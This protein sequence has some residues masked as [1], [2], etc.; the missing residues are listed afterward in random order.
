MGVLTSPLLVSIISLLRLD[1]CLGFCGAQIP[2]APPA[3]IKVRMQQAFDVVRLRS[4]RLI[5]CVLSAV[6]RAS[7]CE[8]EHFATRATMV[9]EGRLFP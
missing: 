3:Q 5:H 8:R 6:A 4:E 9:W 7:E 2:T 1:Y